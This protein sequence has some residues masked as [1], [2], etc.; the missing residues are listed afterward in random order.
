[1]PLYTIPFGKI[2]QTEVLNKEQAQEVEKIH[3]ELSTTLG[4]PVSSIS[5]IK[6]IYYLNNLLSGKSTFKEN[7]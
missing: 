6:E 3:S 5:A 4:T 7:A 2:I 1:T